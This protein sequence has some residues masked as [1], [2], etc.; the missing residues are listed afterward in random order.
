MQFAI[1]GVSII[2]YFMESILTDNFE[3]N[4]L[5]TVLSGLLGQLKEKQFE[6]I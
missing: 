1:F 3:N 4:A 5:V 2:L 6:V